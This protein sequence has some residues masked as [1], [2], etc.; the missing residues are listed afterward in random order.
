M[1]PEKPDL[2]F[3]CTA[4]FPDV[5]LTTITP[6]H[7]CLWPLLADALHQA[8]AESRRTWRVSRLSRQ[9]DRVR[10]LAATSASAAPITGSG[11]GITS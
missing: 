7:L 6:T 10:T 3:R 2:G 5:D 11:D 4:D 8:A 9:F 1:D